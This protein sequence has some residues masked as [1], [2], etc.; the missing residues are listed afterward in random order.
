MHS[1]IIIYGADWCRDTANARRH[2]ETLGVPYAYVNIDR[3]REAEQAVVEWNDGKRRIPTVL[4]HI[5]HSDE[6]IVLLNPPE[7][8]LDDVLRE[9][10][11]LRTVA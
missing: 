11:L 7:H 3:D 1:T 5:G 10:G 6:Q 4:I 9:S 8:Q 2:L